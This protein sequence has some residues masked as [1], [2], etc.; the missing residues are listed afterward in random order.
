MNLLDEVKNNTLNYRVKESSRK[1]SAALS[2]LVDLIKSRSLSGADEAMIQLSVL[3]LDIDQ[4]KVLIS[5]PVLSGFKCEVKEEKMT[6][7]SPSG[8]YMSDVIKI[9]WK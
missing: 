6:D 1:I 8:Y 7:D 3:K 5:N 4:A 2:D 9:S